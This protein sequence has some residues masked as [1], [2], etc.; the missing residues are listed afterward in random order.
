MMKKINFTGKAGLT[1]LEVVA[2]LVILGVFLS[3]LLPAFLQLAAFQGQVAA[4][5]E[6]FVLARGKLEEIAAGAERGRE[7]RFPVPWSHYYWS[8]N[9]QRTADHLVRHILKVRWRGFLGDREIALSRLEA[10]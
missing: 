10:E 6:V 9:E 1:L 8:Y 3:H 7:G 4:E 5:T 2:A